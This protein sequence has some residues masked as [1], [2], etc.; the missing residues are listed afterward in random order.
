[1]T[2]FTRSS[3]RTPMAVCCAAVLLVLLSGCAS[4]DGP[5]TA[6]PAPS[7]EVTAQPDVTAE[8]SA[9][10]P[11]PE[12]EQTTGATTEQSAEAKSEPPAVAAEELVI[13]IADFV[14]ELPEV[15]PPGATV[16]VVNEDTA[17]HTVTSSPAGAFGVTVQG[18]ESAT[19]TVPEKPGEYRLICLFH[20]NMA[21]TLVV[22]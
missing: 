4:D 20:G 10:S 13:T 8:E 18:G 15:V 14:Y 2:L 12:P 16:T 17:A 11:E 21:D 7:Q 5:A 22:G 9:D 1:M 3:N 19:F 6:E